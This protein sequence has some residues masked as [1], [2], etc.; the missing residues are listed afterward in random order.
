MKLLCTIWMLVFCICDISAQWKSSDYFK[1]IYKQ[2]DKILSVAVDNHFASN[3]IVSSFAWNYLRGNYIS[4]SEKDDCISNFNNEQIR[5]GERFKTGIS[6]YKKL[7]EGPYFFGLEYS[8]NV[9]Y[10]TRVHNDLFSLLFKGNKSFEGKSASL[11]PMEI[12]LFHYAAFKAGISKQT[13]KFSFYCK[14]AYLGSKNYLDLKSTKGSLYT[15]PDGRAIDINLNLISVNSRRTSDGFLNF[16]GS[17]VQS[18]F[19]LDYKFSSS[20]GLYFELD[21]LGYIKWNK[22]LV[23]RKVDTSYHFEGILISGILDSFSLDIKD[24]EELKSRFIIEQGGL[25]KRVN[26]PVL[27][28]SGIYH[29]LI[30]DFLRLGLQYQYIQSDYADPLWSGLV[31][32]KLNSKFMLGAEAYYGGYG[33]FNFGFKTGFN[34]FKLLYAE[35]Y[36]NSLNSLLTSKEPYTFIGGAVARLAF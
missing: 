29:D 22:E 3:T 35:A 1:E 26:L 33:K 18:E 23:Q 36:F 21:N 15:E 4:E 27:F 5:V 13:D 2:Q 16:S 6:I 34:L 24:A 8:E 31:D 7:G 30:P 11:N 19:G 14:L 9:F 20:T 25:S 32:I 10:E 28:K 12:K 17:G